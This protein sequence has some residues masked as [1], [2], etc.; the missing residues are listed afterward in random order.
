MFALEKVTGLESVDYCLESW[1]VD[2]G[3]LYYSI[4]SMIIQ[5]LL[6]GVIVSISYIKICRKLK[7]RMSQKTKR[8]VLVESRKRDE[9]RTKKTNTLLIS[10]ALIFGISWLPLNIFNTVADIHTF[11]DTQT[12]R[13]IFA[14]CHMAGMSSAVSNPWLYGWLNENFRKEFKEIFSLCCSCCPTTRSGTDLPGNQ[15]K[16]IK[17][18]VLYNHPVR[19]GNGVPEPVGHK[20][21]SYA[22]SEFIEIDDNGISPPKYDVLV[23]ADLK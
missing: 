9:K 5:Y 22:E 12:F 3:R 19:E 23:V 18:V 4:F 17:S 16:K 2:Y 20:M 13:I 15:R 21:K 6:P 11:E 8:T 7:G 10:I 1:P 14:V